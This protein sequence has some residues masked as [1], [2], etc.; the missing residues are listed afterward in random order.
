[1]ITVARQAKNIILADDDEDDC[2]LFQDVIGDLGLD[3]NI[4]VAHNGHELLQLLERDR[5]PVPDLI[6]L[7]MNM[8]LRD[9]MECLKEIRKSAIHKEV[10]VIILSTSSHTQIVD[11]VFKEGANLYIRKPDSF[12]KLRTILDKLF[13]SMKFNLLDRQ[14]EDFLITD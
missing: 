10:P 6:F 1:M 11:N 3:V 5:H 4:T 13:F 12:D 7:D 8:P 9:G 2:L 14:R